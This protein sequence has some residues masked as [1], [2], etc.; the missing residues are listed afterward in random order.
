MSCDVCFFEWCCS[1]YYNI[2]IEH[3][4]VDNIV[5]NV[6][7]VALFDSGNTLTYLTGEAYTLVTKIAY[8]LR[9]LDE[10]TCLDG[11]SIM[12]PLSSIAFCFVVLLTM[13][14]GGTSQL[15]YGCGDSLVHHNENNIKTVL[16][17]MVSNATRPS[18]FYKTTA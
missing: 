1:P 8:T 7:L 14:G 17:D 11:G 4:S 15:G 12:Y 6:S 2:E 10:S 5:I 16:G 9:E 3:I 13:L 18:G